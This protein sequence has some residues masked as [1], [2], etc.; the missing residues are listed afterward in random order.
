MVPGS[1]CLQVYTHTGMLRLNNHKIASFI[2]HFLCSFPLKLPSLSQCLTCFSLQE[3]DKTAM[4]VYQKLHISI[5]WGGGGHTNAHQFQIALWI[6]P[7][8]THQLKRSSSLLHSPHSQLLYQRC[9]YPML[10][11]YVTESFPTSLCS[12]SDWHLRQSVI[13]EYIHI[14]YNIMYM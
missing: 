9:I 12:H 3:N 10:G 13:E 8:E 5:M 4:T 14:L 7:L 1:I 11:S 2:P 6:S